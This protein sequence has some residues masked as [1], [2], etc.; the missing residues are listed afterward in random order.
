MDNV[1][2]S[3]K[4]ESKVITQVCCLMSLAMESKDKLH[5]KIEYTPHINWLEYS[6][7]HPACGY[8]SATEIGKFRLLDGRIR[9]KEDSVLQKLLDLEDKLIE[10]LGEY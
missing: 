1:T 9:M 6:V 2:E 8:N 4:A 10:L 5:I 7:T 3:K